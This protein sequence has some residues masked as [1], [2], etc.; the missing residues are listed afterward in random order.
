MPRA[1]D[2][3]KMRK[4]VT[5]NAR[6]R[7]EGTRNLLA[8][9]RT[10]GVAHVVAQSIAF[11]Y[12]PGSRP[13]RESDPLDL[14]DGGNAGI[15]ARGVASLEAQV[16]A[17]PW[18]GIV[19]RYGRLYGPGA[20]DRAPPPALHVDAA[21]RAFTMSWRTTASPT[22]HAREQPSGRTP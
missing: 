1:F 2:P 14:A 9:A 16:L 17:G 5:R 12:A 6:I 15:S 3:D 11:V 8:A 7:N 21:A 13:Y 4:I 20:P 18:R 22:A 19:V 10:A